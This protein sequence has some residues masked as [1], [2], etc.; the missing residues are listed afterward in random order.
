MPDRSTGQS[1][2]V[3]TTAERAPYPP[4]ANDGRAGVVVA[5]GGIVGVTAALMLQRAGRQ[6]TLLEAG[7]IGRGI[8]GGSTAKVTSQHVL[9]YRA[10][11]ARHG[12]SA[13]A[14]YARS[15]EAG[16]DWI[17]R[18]VDTLAIDCEFETAQAYVYATGE[19]QAVEV[20]REAECAARLGLP[21]TFVRGIDG[22]PFEVCR[23]K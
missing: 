8:T 16:R 23:M 20:E 17:A 22:L 21:A 3:A 4:L 2:W 14:L 9:I 6:V 5:G 10:L 13:A 12:R 15:N 7:R 1:C 19:E 18:Q 11:E